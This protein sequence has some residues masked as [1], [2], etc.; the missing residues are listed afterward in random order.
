MNMILPLRLKCDLDILTKSIREMR[1]AFCRKFLQMAS[2]QCG[3]FRLIDSKQFRRLY[4]CQATLCQT[5]LTREWHGKKYLVKVLDEG[6]E[7]GGKPYR[8]LSGVAKQIS[9]QIVNGYLWFSLIPTEDK[10]S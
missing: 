9:G 8:S 3:Y 6:F 10:K 1:Q 2:Q 7:Y 4:L 5:D